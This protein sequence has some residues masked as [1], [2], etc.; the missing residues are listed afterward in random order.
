MS[1]SDA[2]AFKAVFLA[3]F[4]FV[5]LIL[6]LV[7]FLMTRSRNKKLREYTITAEA[8]VIDMSQERHGKHHSGGHNSNAPMWYPTYQYAVGGQVFTHK[9]HV[10]TSAKPYEVGDRLKILVDPNNYEKYVIP[11][12]KGFKL[13][14]GILWALFAFFLIGI[15]CAAVF[16]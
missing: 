5:D 4:I 7:P 6:F 15:V 13:A 12:S 14:T 10:G 9:S 2:G 16:M 1:A 8:T 11:D 3:V